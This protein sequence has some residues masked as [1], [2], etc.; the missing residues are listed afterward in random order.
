M[1][2]PAPLLAR[3]KKIV[4]LSAAVLAVVGIVVGALVVSGSQPSRLAGVNHLNQLGWLCKS[5]FQEGAY[6]QS[7]CIHEAAASLQDGGYN[8]ED[9]VLDEEDYERMLGEYPWIWSTEEPTTHLAQAGSRLRILSWDNYEPVVQFDFASGPLTVDDSKVWLLDDGRG[10]AWAHFPAEADTVCSQDEGDGSP[11]AGVSTLAAGEGEEGPEMA[12]VT[13]DLDPPKTAEPSEAYCIELHYSEDGGASRQSRWVLFDLPLDEM[14]VQIQERLEAA[15][16]AALPASSATEE[17]LKTH[18]SPSARFERLR[19]IKQHN[20]WAA[21]GGEPSDDEDDQDDGDT[22]EGEDGETVS[23]EDACF[24]EADSVTDCL[25]DL[26][27]YY[28]GSYVEI[29][30]VTVDLPEGWD[31]FS[32]QQKEI[33]NPYGC[34]RRS[35]IDEQTGRCLDYGYELFGYDG[36]PDW[37]TVSLPDYLVQQEEEDDEYEGGLYRQINPYGCF[38]FDAIDEQTG[39]CSFGRWSIWGYVY[40]DYGGGEPDYDDED[41]EDPD[42]PGEETPDWSGTTLYVQTF[43]NANDKEAYFTANSERHPCQAIV[44]GTSQYAI[45]GQLYVIYA[46]EISPASLSALW[47]V[48]DTSQFEELDP[49]AV[50]YDALSCPT[51][52]GEL[53][54]QALLCQKNGSTAGVCASAGLSNRILEEVE[55]VGRTCQAVYDKIE[56]RKADRPHLDDL[57]DCLLL[58]DEL[59]SDFFKTTQIVVEGDEYYW[60]AAVLGGGG[61]YDTVDSQLPYTVWEGQPEMNLYGHHTRFQFEKVI[62]HEYLHKFYFRNLPLKERMR[63]H[64]EMLALYEDRRQLVF[65]YLGPSSLRG[66]VSSRA[67]RHGAVSLTQIDSIID[68]INVLAP[69]IIA[70]LPQEIRL[71]YDE[72]LQDRHGIVAFVYAL[73]EEQINDDGLRYDTDL[74]QVTGKRVFAEV[75]DL[76]FADEFDTIVAEANSQLGDDPLLPPSLVYSMSRIMPPLGRSSVYLPPSA[77][78]GPEETEEVEDQP[79]PPTDAEDTVETEE[80]E[81]PEEIGDALE[82]ILNELLSLERPGASWRFDFIY[83]ALSG[84][85]TE[86]YPILALETAHPLSDW[87][88]AH[89]G[90]YFDRPRLTRYFEYHPPL[91][92]EPLSVQTKND[93]RTAEVLAVKEQIEDFFDD[94]RHWPTGSEFNRQILGRLKLYIYSY[95]RNPSVVPGSPDSKT[96]EGTVEYTASML[97]QQITQAT[98]DA[99]LL[100][101]DVHYPGPDE[102]HV[103]VGVECK[104]GGILAGGNPSLDETAEYAAGDLLLA[105]RA[106]AIIYQLEGEAQA[107][108]DDNT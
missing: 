27:D 76:K 40:G 26:R 51:R 28:D 98:L 38:E 49:K 37:L 6:Y 67:A 22:Y 97:G 106:V 99:D 34:W 3:R 50:L 12:V 70:Q 94:N 95:N 43:E 13:I 5:V 87:L 96:E 79:E 14:S 8:Y 102:L 42:F 19:S 91:V 61:V 59:R 2:T 81:E 36:T 44:A 93:R 65:G 29:E 35:S 74:G 75:V 31:D 15:E 47:Y 108:C 69:Q 10:D 18:F 32:R 63:F 60:L 84:F 85:F 24:L 77:A 52:L 58:T 92:S 78:S 11:A 33:A 39:R 46:D 57:A 62:L 17:A 73:T 53:A 105:P 30:D 89:Y 80:P 104:E 82:E 23:D 9:D 86:G 21:A 66:E 54:A 25:P 101:S 41:A 83:V 55:A 56:L 103:I 7:E 45:A 88:E 64:Q 107:R 100:S 71:E 20:L 68:D 4:V 1:P 16:L 90:R 48:F 72:F